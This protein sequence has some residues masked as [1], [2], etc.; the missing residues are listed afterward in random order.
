MD[1]EKLRRR[2]TTITKRKKIRRMSK[3]LNAK[4]NLPDTFRVLEKD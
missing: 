3:A 4:N 2:T 1:R